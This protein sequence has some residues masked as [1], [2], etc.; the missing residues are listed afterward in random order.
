MSA[1][2]RRRAPGVDDDRTRDNR[3][4]RRL[5]AR[6]VA[7]RAHRR[8]VG[9]G[10]DSRTVADRAERSVDVVAVDP[11]PGRHAASRQGHCRSR[12][13]CPDVLVHDPPH[14]PFT[15]GKANDKLNPDKEKPSVA[16][17][18]FGA[19]RRPGVP[20]RALGKDL[21]RGFESWS[22]NYLL[23]SSAILPRPNAHIVAI[24]C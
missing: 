5:D 23:S 20:L 9:V 22:R 10:D 21:R 6:A 8:A 17:P 7:V 18:M 16:R 13:N 19:K 11:G 1:Q 14:F 24:T 12:Q 15:I 2:G 3:L 4:R